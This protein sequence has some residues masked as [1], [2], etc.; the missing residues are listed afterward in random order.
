MESINEL[1]NQILKLTRDYSKKVHAQFRP[2]GDETRSKWERGMPI[3]YAGRVFTDD[4][5]AAAVSS[6]LDF[7]LTL[8]PEG[9]NMEKEITE[10]LGVNKCLLVNSGSSANL[11][12]IS[13]L[14]SHKLGNKKINPGDEIITVAAGFP[15]TVAPIIQVGAKP[16]FIDADTIT[17]NANCEQL[18]KAYKP[19]KNQGCN[20]GTCAWKSI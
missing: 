13:A 6:T 16:V 17:G 1:K 11:I 8:G 9:H 7:W 5:V 12:A 14:T 20:D 15:T 19:K 18:E 3:P 4:E 2:D 10:F